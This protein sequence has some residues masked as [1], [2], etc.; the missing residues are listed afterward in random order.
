MRRLNCFFAGAVLFGLS[1]PAQAQTAPAEPGTPAPA[2]FWRVGPIDFSGLVD[3]YYS[4]GFNH[5]ASRTNQLRNFDVQA[6][7][8]SLNMARMTLEHAPDPIGFRMD[9]G[10]GRTFDI[11]HSGEKDLAVMRNIEQ[12]FV[13]VKPKNAKGFQADFGKFV[14]SAGAEVIGTNSNWNYSRSLLFAWAIPY[15]HFGLRTSMPLH[16]YITAGAQL[17]NGWNNVQDNNSG[18]TVGL[19]GALTTSKVTWSHTYYLG[20]EKPGTNRGYRRLYDTTLLLTPR[21]KVSFYLNVD[22]G[23]ERRVARGS[24]TWKGIAGA[25]RFAPNQWFALSPRLEWFSD[26][27]GFATGTPQSLKEFTL[28]AEFKIREGILMRPEYRR[29]WSDR[30]FFDRG[31]STGVHKNQDTLL[32]GIVAYFG[33]KR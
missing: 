32:A 25:A 29:D 27:D 31:A 28:T 24:D 3:G 21:P 9:L 10:F 11:V 4:L 33:P 2:S 19:T 15:Y 23:A 30:P 13:S 5:P 17:V 16:K 6:N 14:T 7:R 22:Y 1:A 20:P 12:V 8:L 18:K 26:T